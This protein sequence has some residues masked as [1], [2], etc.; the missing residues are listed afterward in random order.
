MKNFV[1][2]EKND[3]IGDNNINKNDDVFSDVIGEDNVDIYTYAPRYFIPRTEKKRSRFKF[4]FIFKNAFKKLFRKNRS[5]PI[6]LS[7]DSC[8][9]SQAK[10]IKIYIE[11]LVELRYTYLMFMNLKSSYAEEIKSLISTYESNL[12]LSKS[13]MESMINDI[14]RSDKP[15]DVKQSLLNQIFSI[16]GED[17]MNVKF[18]QVHYYP[19]HFSKKHREEYLKMLRED[20]EQYPVPS[21]A[22]H[23]KR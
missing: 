17:F 1:Y 22:R 15:D 13:L 6:V 3:Q 23:F 16:V 14:M 5:K 2:D 12:A 18:N 11:I 21:R 10:F 20:L 4:I 9:I 8:V 7:D 19:K